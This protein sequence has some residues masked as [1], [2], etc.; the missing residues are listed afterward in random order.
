MT[1]SQSRETLTMDMNQS[2]ASVSF[3]KRNGWYV[4]RGVAFLLGLLFV[5]AVVATGLLVYYYAPHVRESGQDSQDLKDDRGRSPLQPSTHSPVETSPETPSKEKINVRLPRALKPL[6]YMVKLQPFINGNFSIMGYVEVEME[7]VEPTSNITL[8]INDIITNNETIKLTPSDDRTG[9]KIGIVKHLYDKERE[10]YIAKLNKE[11]KPGKKYVLSMEFVG[12]LNDKLLGFYRS[13]YTDE[14]GNEKWI[15]VTQFQPTDARRAFP[16][17]DE[18]ALKATY[19][20]FLGRESSMS[21]LSNMPKF[22]TIP[23]EGQDGW[24]WDHFNTSVPMSTYLVAFVISDFA[25]ME[26]NDND[27]VLFRVK[28]R[29]A[30]INQADYALLTGP[31]I[32]THFEDYFNV[33]FPLPKQDMIAIPDFSAGAMEN[34]GLITYRETAM[35]YDP[36]VSSARNKQRV[37]IVVSHELAHQWFGNLVTP[38][39]WTD[40]WLNEGFASFMEYIGVDHAEPTWNMMEQF[41]TE[42][43]QRVFSLDWL[44]SSHPISI[45][46]GHPDEINEIFDLISYLKGASLIRMMNFFLTEKTLRKGLSNYL[47]GLK[48]KSAE[49]DDL[50]QYLTEAAHE[51]ATLP[52]DMTVKEE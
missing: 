29:K 42:D 12:Y 11:L 8:H 16:C 25:S 44:E 34:W 10:F 51:D 33:S 19:E 9:S 20:I 4:N 47:I 38:D 22:E 27:H 15:A 2:A 1:S 18:P 21:S 17:F 45:P 23:I 52:P 6:H 40:L 48:Y 30:A 31:K 14:Q 39:W 50:W 5:S 26:S 24:V 28:A 41:V 43:V 36:E 7:V 3:G 35:L 13:S 37:A 32:L 49:Q 46:V